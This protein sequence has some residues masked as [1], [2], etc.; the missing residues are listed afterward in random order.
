[1][2]RQRLL[3]I[4]PGIIIWFILLFPLV[5][6]LFIPRVV[7]YGLIAFYVYW[8]YRSL[9]ITVLGFLGY[10]EIKVAKEVDWKK[11]YV[12]NG[13]EDW[14]PWDQVHHVVIIPTAGEPLEKLH[15]NI[16]ALVN[17]TLDKD[18]MTVVVALEER[19]SNS[20]EVGRKLKARYSG[21]FAHF[22]T[23]FHPDGLEGEVI[24]KAS[25]E[26]WAA[27][28]AKKRLLDEGYDLSNLTLTSCDADGQ[29]HPA[30]FSALT[31]KFSS[32]PNR[33]HRFWQSPIV[34]YN[35][36][37]EVPALVRVVEIL[38]VTLN[39]ANLRD[40]G[41]LIFNYSCYSASFLL[42]GS[43]GFWDT[44]II[45]EDWHIFLQTFFEHEGKVAVEPIYLPT[46]V[47]APESKGYW[48]TIQNRYKQCMR[49][50]WG[51]TDIPY[52]IKRSFN[53][54]EIPFPV[55]FLRVFKLIESHV[56]WSTNW[57]LITLGASIPPLIN[58]AFAQTCLG[59]NLPRVSQAIF[60]LS[61]LGMLAIVVIDVALRPPRPDDIPWWAIPLNYLQWLLLPVATLFMA[62]LPA[63]HSH[64]RLMLGKYMEYHVTGEA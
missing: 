18:Q 11:K 60:T 5:G 24:G 15:G 32:D 50:A 49:H 55:K 46:S 1:M 33:Y 12:R 61:L 17:Q 40:P 53:H 26:A 10:Y 58:P 34:G 47:D 14:L 3:E 48:A 16:D 6:S 52:A 9:K 8:L 2:K 4:L 38:S 57:F 64:T 7:A 30:Y 42:I 19:V 27:K 39:L 20:R 25:N 43:V 51:I 13:K 22:W 23:V 59:A 21:E 31:Y 37:W 63:L 62:C 54:P 56:F 41:Q 29:F 36:L 28:E 44:D 45:P 35:N